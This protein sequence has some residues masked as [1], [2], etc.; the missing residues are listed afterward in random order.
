[1]PHYDDKIASNDKKIILTL[2]SQLQKNKYLFN[3]NYEINCGLVY[4]S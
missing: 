2:L 1:M 4:P 3:N